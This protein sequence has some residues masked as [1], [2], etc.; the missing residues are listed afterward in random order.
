MTWDVQAQY[1][2]AR[3]SAEQSRDAIREKAEFYLRRLDENAPHISRAEHVRRLIEINHQRLD[4]VP[5]LERYPELAGMREV[6][7]AR[8]RGLRDGAKLTEAQW[9]AQCGAWFYLQRYLMQPGP[10]RCSLVFF[11]TSDHGPLFG[12]NLDTTLDEKFGPPGWIAGERILRGGVSSGVWMD[13]Q[14]PEIFPAS[15]EELVNRQCTST[16]Q[17]VEMYERYNYF[18]GPGNKIVVDR[19]HRVAMVEKSACRIGVRYSPDGFGFITAMTAEEPGM[20]AFLAD[21][22]TASVEARGLGPGNADEAYWAKQDQ[23]RELLNELLDEARKQPTLELM[24]RI[25]HF[26]SPDRGN[27]CGNGDR[28][29][30]DGPESEYTLRTVIWLLA[31]GRAMWWARQGDSP[32]WENRREDIL[33]NDVPLWN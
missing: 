24:Q 4:A 7:D 21:R 29:I 8:W 33:F 30:P 22:R 32:V 3:R 6:I 27:V 31:E 10:A 25:M 9:A 17:V 19:D 1:E 16:D 11:P 28:Y 26:R 18:W 5:D 14:S 12:S 23:R 15:V 2:A 20:H 13:E